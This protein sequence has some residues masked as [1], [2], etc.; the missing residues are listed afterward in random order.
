MITTVRKHGHSDR[1]TVRERKT[2]RH[3]RQV[4]KGRT[5]GSLCSMLDRGIGVI[6]YAACWVSEPTVLLDNR[7]ASSL[8]FCAVSAK[9][10]SYYRQ[11]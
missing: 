2:D 6:Q 5:N 8:H 11:C 4:K 7:A 3:S 9:I 10:I 1:Q